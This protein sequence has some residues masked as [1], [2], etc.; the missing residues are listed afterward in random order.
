MLVEDRQ[1]C[2]GASAR[3]QQRNDGLVSTVESKGQ[4]ETKPLQKI[5]FR[6]R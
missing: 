2:Q 3:L 1:P 6:R 4:L 5:S